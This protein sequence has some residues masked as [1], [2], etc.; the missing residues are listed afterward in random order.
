MLPCQHRRIVPLFDDQ[1]EYLCTHSD[2]PNP[3]PI[4][5][6]Y[7]TRCTNCQLRQGSSQGSRPDLQAIERTLPASR[8]TPPTFHSDGSIE[9]QRSNSEPLDI[10]GYVRDS[11]NHWLFHPLWNECALRHAVAYFKAA[12]GCVTIVSRCNNPQASEFGQRVS[13]KTC[14]RCKQ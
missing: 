11:N 13:H 5:F 4:F 3:N 14:E 6:E 1:Y 7:D 8:H 9:Y 12:C 10:D 2:R